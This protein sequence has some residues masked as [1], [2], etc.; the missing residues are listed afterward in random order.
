MISCLD[1]GPVSLRR[2]RQVQVLW[3]LTVCLLMAVTWKLWTPQTVF[4][5]VPLVGLLASLPVAIHWIVLGVLVGSCLAILLIRPSS[6]YQRWALVGFLLAACLLVALDQH[7]LQP[8]FYQCL[9]FALVM[10]CCAPAR[11]LPLLR[12]LL[13]SVYVFSAL[14]KFDY[15][16][17]HSLGPQLLEAGCQLVGISSIGWPAPLPVLV[18][19]LFPAV[20]LLGA[21][22]LLVPQLRKLALVAMVSMHLG[23]LLILG[24]LG[25]DHQPGVLAWNLS[26]VL[27]VLLLFGGP[28]GSEEVAT[29]QVTDDSSRAVRF[30]YLFVAILLLPLLEPV[31]LVD[32]WLAWGLYSPRNSRV[33]LE[34]YEPQAGLLP[35][36]VQPFIRP[37]RQRKDM[38][39]VRMDLWSLE[40][41]GVPIYPQGRFQLGVA[42]SLIRNSGPR[43][44]VAT[45][46][47]MSHRFTG[48][49]SA[50]E[51]K[52]LDALERELEKF[53]INADP[54]N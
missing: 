48:K 34:V 3:V 52:D 10:I 40:S 53:I 36:S 27:Q 35:V 22:G 2:W 21:V 13:V 4:P 17:L 54:G 15:Q 51:I 23:L 29:N 28:T 39:Q 42:T 8:W 12:A 49:R 5:R 1:L 25:L 46:Q 6:H 47:S 20:E 14:G 9:L 7:R 38:V 37:A 26:F 30:N 32:H 43:A 33:T 18:S 50:V 31:G 11:A 44:F 19:G 41:L 24:P 45:L 16:F